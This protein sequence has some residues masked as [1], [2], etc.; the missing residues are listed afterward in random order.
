M[1]K[2]T[3]NFPELS[4]YDL[5]T[6]FCQLKEVCGADPGGMIS[7]QFKSRPTTAKDIAL[8]LNITYK[9]LKAQ[10]ELQEKYKE[11]YEFVRDFF[12]NLDLQEEVNKWLEK[13]LEDGRLG[14]ILQ[15]IVYSPINVKQAG[16]IPDTGEDLTEKLTNIFSAHPNGEFYFPNGVYTINGSITL[17]SNVKFILE[18]DAFISTPGN[19]LF[20]FILNGKS[21]EMRG[22]Q[23]QAGSIENFNSKTLSG[24]VF[25]SGLFNFINCNRVYISDVVANFNTT[26]NTFKFTDCKNVLISR[27]EFYKFL[28]AGVILYDGCKNIRVE[29]SIFKECKR[30][31]EKQYCY[32]V[33]SGFSTYSQVVKAIEN[34]VIENCEFEDCDW[35][36]CDCHGGKNIRFSN[37][38]MHNC[39]RFITIY[40]D[41]RPQL[42]EY[43]F[44]NAVVENCFFYNDDDYEPPTPDASIYCNGRYN[45]YFSNLTFR[46]IVLLNP[47]CMD[48]SNNV[49]YGAI[50]T[51]YN[52]N[53]SFENVK[54]E[55]T[56]TYAKT[57]YVM[58]L[59]ATRN[60]KIRNM[61]IKGMPGLSSDAPIRLQYVTGDI[62]DLTVLNNGLTY[63]GVYISKVSAVKL[64]KQIHG[65]LT[66]QY[67]TSRDAQLIS[68]GDIIP[69]SFPEMSP[70]NMY[71][72]ISESGYRLSLSSSDTQVTAN[73]T[74]TSGNNEIALPEDK[75]YLAPVGT[76]VH[77]KVGDNEID[78][79][80]T[81]FRE[82]YFTVANTPN[83][84]GS[85]T[86]TINRASRVTITEPN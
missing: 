51:N 61:Q 10:I 9:L 57:P 81:D 75:Y 60:L 20:T 52:R 78:T 85:G 68:A 42:D 1:S 28:Y 38:K 64:G 12:E 74:V 72:S 71:A 47:V 23:V 29:N 8:L 37:L 62:D 50:F 46:N 35:E 59:R 56:R 73:I 44:N 77:I 65:Y 26:G 2:Y 24:N 83:F 43:E 27:C 54:I 76:S 80:I 19:D 40:S 39:N 55:A 33:A 13:A 30:S 66:N 3:E 82:N 15:G 34:Y 32:P 4:N 69:F 70:S 49:E 79:F 6:V 48:K 36:G 53:V 31:T 84:S 5:S 25:N 14:N 58:Y 21:F 45:R 67:Y 18:D 16:A 11:L 7:M 41:N 22:G 86:V 63:A 17:N